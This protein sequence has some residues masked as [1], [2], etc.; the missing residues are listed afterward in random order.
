MVSKLNSDRKAGEGALT[1]IGR[2]YG[3]IG[4]T[5]LFN[6]LGVRIIMIGMSPTS[7]S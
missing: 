5:G 4:F 2:I 6:G 3:K 1:A 7:K